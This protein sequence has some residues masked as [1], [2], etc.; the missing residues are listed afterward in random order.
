MQ[1]SN[2]ATDCEQ[3]RQQLLKVAEQVRVSFNAGQ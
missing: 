2:I 3:M 1:G